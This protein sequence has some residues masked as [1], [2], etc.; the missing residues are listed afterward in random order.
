[1]LKFGCQFE[2]GTFEFVVLEGLQLVTIVDLEQDQTKTRLVVEMKSKHGGPDMGR[3]F[4]GDIDLEV[5]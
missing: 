1:M 4:C 2:S 5:L 3:L